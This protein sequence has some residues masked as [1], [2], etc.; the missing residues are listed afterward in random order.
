MTEYNMNIPYAKAKY[1]EYKR[2]GIPNSLIV[3]FDELDFVYGNNGFSK[4]LAADAI[5]KH[6]GNYLRA[7]EEIITE[8]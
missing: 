1:E 4:T 3:V 5:K 2:T 8:E 6:N 7:L